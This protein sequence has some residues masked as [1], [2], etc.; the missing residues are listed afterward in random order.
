MREKN[1]LDATNGER[2]L[3]YSFESSLVFV[4]CWGTKKR[5]MC[6][7]RTLHFEQQRRK[8]NKLF[9]SFLAMSEAMIFPVPS[10]II[11]SFLGAMNL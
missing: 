3:N 5:A 11:L 9:L 2:F 8:D 7:N 6:C 10:D 1:S 4:Y